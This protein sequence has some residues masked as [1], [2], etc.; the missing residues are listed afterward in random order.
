MTMNNSTLLGLRI[1]REALSLIVVLGLALVGLCSCRGTV[2]IPVEMPINELLD[3]QA[4]AL[5]DQWVRQET[6]IRNLYTDS[7]ATSGL[8]TFAT[9]FD[10]IDPTVSSSIIEIHTFAN[11]TLAQASLS[12][13]PMAV[14][15]DKAANP[16][17]GWAYL[18]VN[19]DRFILDCTDETPVPNHCYVLLRYEEYVIVYSTDL[20]G[21]LSLSNL[22]RFL[23]A[24]DDFMAQFLAETHLERGKRRVPNDSELGS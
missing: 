24:T 19:A 11:P 17:D 14:N 22:R 4:K 2:R 13:S 6:S 12:P 1:G 3:V 5:G 20:D 16:P 8:W 18:P 10:H 23:E 9:G 21:A 15:I 7:S